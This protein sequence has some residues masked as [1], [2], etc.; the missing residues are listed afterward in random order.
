MRKGIYCIEGIWNESNIRDKSTVLPILDLLNKRNICDYIY[1]DCATEEELAFFIKKWKRND[2]RSKYPVLYFAFHGKKGA[3][4][5]NNKKF[6]GLDSL[7]ELLGKSASGKLIHFGSCSTLKLKPEA[8]Q[9]FLYKTEA[10]A[11][12]GYKKDIDW[13]LSTAFD[14]LIFEAIQYHPLD[15]KGIKNIKA[16][17]ERE[18]GNLHEVLKSEIVIN[19]SVSF[20]RP[21]GR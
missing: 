16:K 15:N 8:I 14:A 4:Q 1:H 21:Q 6:Y 2:I 3:I 7:A 19:E 18:Y 11:V 10:I 17:V 9:D 20:R 12:I 5:L 13:L